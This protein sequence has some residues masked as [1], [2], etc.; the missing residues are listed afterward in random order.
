MFLSDMTAAID[1][2]TIRKHKVTHIVNATNRGVPNRFEG[3]KS[4]PGIQYLNVDINDDLDADI[5][6]HFPRVCEWIDGILRQNEE[7]NQDDEQS[8][9]V[10]VHCFC[11]VSRSASLILSY[12]VARRQMSLRSAWELVKGESVG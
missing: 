9:V 10:L 2:D 11:G 3:T 1:P 6:S 4:N 7:C 5:G 8:N 12:L